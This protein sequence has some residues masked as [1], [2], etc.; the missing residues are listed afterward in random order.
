MAARRPPGRGLSRITA[1]GELPAPIGD[2]LRSSGRSLTLLSL[3]SPARCGVTGTQ[4]AS[5]LRGTSLEIGPGGG[6][7]MTAATNEPG[8]H[9]AARRAEQRLLRLAVGGRRPLPLI[10]RRLGGP[11][12]SSC[13]CRALVDEPRLQSDHRDRGQQI[14]AQ[15]SGPVILGKEW[16]A[17]CHAFLAAIISR[18]G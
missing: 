3:A 6:Y 16:R 15:T 17:R 4:L 13:S 12:R 10:A 9:R 18:L 5:T 2:R 14:S 1:S 7:E 11:G 8:L